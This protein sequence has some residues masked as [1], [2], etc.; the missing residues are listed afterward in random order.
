M[1]APG[2]DRLFRPTAGRLF[3]FARLGVAQRLP[4]LS[5]IDAKVIV[6]STSSADVSSMASLRVSH[7]EIKASAAAMD[8][9]AVTV[10][11]VGRPNLDPC[12]PTV[13]P[14]AL[15]D[16]RAKARYVVNA[17]GLS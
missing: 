17:R 4:R 1:I 13:A 3:E 8:V 10:C 2:P 6:H 11:R 16:G 5:A 7:T 14:S 9:M 12:S 15:L